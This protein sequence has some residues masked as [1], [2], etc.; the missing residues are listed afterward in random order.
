MRQRLLR[1]TL[2]M[3]VGATYLGYAVAVKFGHGLG[4]AVCPFKMLTGMPCPL[5]GLTHS[6]GA[7]F[8]GHFEE[9]ITIHPFGL[10]LL[11]A[12]MIF[13]VLNVHAVG[14]LA[15]SRERDAPP[16]VIERLEEWLTAT[17]RL[18]RAIIK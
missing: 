6:W 5:C 10:P 15:R 4:F 2:L 14:S 12:W 9:S 17:F 18:R 11:T 13:L 16:V 1:R 3:G 7:A 8:G